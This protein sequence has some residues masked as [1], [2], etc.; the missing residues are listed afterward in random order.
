MLETGEAFASFE[1]VGVGSVLVELL[2]SG[3]GFFAGGRLKDVTRLVLPL[4]PDFTPVSASFDP[5]AGSSSRPNNAATSSSATMRSAATWVC[6]IGRF[7]PA[8]AISSE[9]V[10]TF[11]H[12]TCQPR[13]ALKDGAKE[14]QS[15][16][17]LDV[18]VE[19]AENGLFLANVTMP[20]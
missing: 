10:V 7:L 17:A 9:G 19:S 12:F 2:W 11:A 1:R 16:R 8:P 5:G 15:F 13:Y 14:N 20:M 18:G 4:I 3:I 6:P